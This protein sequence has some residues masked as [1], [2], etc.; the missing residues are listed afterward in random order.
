MG[1]KWNQK[2]WCERDLFVLLAR[3]SLAV[4]TQKEGTRKNSSWEE[5]RI[6]ALCQLI[7]QWVTDSLGGVIDSWKEIDLWLLETHAQLVQKMLDPFG[8]TLLGCLR[9]QAMNSALQNRYSLGR[10]LPPRY[11]DQ[12]IQINN[13]HLVGM[14]GRPMLSIFTNPSAR[15]GYDTRSIFKR[16]LTSLNSEF[17]FS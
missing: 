1:S 4:D 5:E 15:A 10:Q 6:N 11:R 3:G 8:I 16:R 14:P 17:S 9:C 2:Q 7:G 12:A 13:T